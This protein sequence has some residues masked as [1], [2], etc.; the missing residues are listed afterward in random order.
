MARDGASGS[1]GGVGLAGA[2]ARATIGLILGRLPAFLI[3]LAAARAFGAS[4]RTDEFFFCWSLVAFLGTGWNALGE[5]VSVPFLVEW[6]QWG[7]NA[8]AYIVRIGA[9]LGLGSVVLLLAGGGVSVALGFLSRAGFLHFFLPL[10]LWAILSGR[11]SI[12]TGLLL[13]CERYMAATFS[14]AITSAFVLGGIGLLSGKL[15]EDILPLSYAAGELVRVFFLASRARD[16]LREGVPPGVGELRSEMGRWWRASRYQ[17]GGTLILG[18]Y[19]VLDRV[20]AGGMD[21][22]SITIL[23]YAERLWSIPVGLLTGG[24]LSVNLVRWSDVALQDEGERALVRRTLRAAWRVFVCTVP[25]AVAIAGARGPVIGLLFGARRLSGDDLEALSAAFGALMIGLP[26]YLGSMVVVRAI[27]ALRRTPYLFWIALVEVAVK[28]AAN[29]VLA[30]RV[31]VAGLALSTIIMY[32]VA[33]ILQC[34]VL[35]QGCGQVSLPGGDGSTG[36]AGREAS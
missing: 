25:A 34:L 3:P 21:A 14:P 2:Y 30:P 33:G 20:W 16:R 7:W 15:Q 5:V 1:A 36:V 31:G 12:L 28:A 4:P 8:G 32:S 22:G 17:L 18:L 10:S 11:A 9:W 23:S 35:C 13:S 27:T 24:F 29:A 19:P 26:C 6:R